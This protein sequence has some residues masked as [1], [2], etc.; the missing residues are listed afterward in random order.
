M[1]LKLFSSFLALF[2]ITTV[3]AQFDYLPLSN[4]F[5]L[6]YNHL[7]YDKESNIHSSIRPFRTSEVSQIVNVDSVIEEDFYSNKFSQTWFGGALFNKHFVEVRTEDFDLSLDPI[8]NF[9]VG[10]ERGGSSNYTYTNTRGVYVQGRIGKQV[11]F[12]TSFAENQSRFPDYVTSF[13]NGS[14][15]V[16]GQGQGRV[17]KEDGFDYQNAYG[18]VSYTPSKYFNFSLGQGKHFFG[19]GYRSMFLSDGTFNYPFFLCSILF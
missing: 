11:T 17:F 18:I 9:N 7:L 1:T 13:V 15:V 19:E 2:I 3:N 16:P 14:K 5:E 10:K 8:L 6:K 12:M 4:D